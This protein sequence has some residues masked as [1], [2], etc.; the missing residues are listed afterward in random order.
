VDERVEY[1]SAGSWTKTRRGEE[2]LLEDKKTFDRR[3]NGRGFAEA[4]RTGHGRRLHYLQ[5]RRSCPDNQIL[6]CG[7]ATPFIDVR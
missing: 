3:A 7:L 2:I 5:G 1:E 6:F 4:A